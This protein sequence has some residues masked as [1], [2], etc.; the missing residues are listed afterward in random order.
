MRR[1]RKI[2]T[3]RLAILP[4]AYLAEQGDLSSQ[5]RKHHGIDE[6]YRDVITLG[7]CAYQLHTYLAL[8]REHFGFHVET[9]VRVQQRDMLDQEGGAGQLMEHA[10][11]IIDGA[12]R[13]GIVKAS[14]AAGE[15]DIP[16]EMNVALALLL[17][18]P[19]SPDFAENAALKAVRIADMSPNVDWYFSDCLARSQAQIKRIFTSMN[20]W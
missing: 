16:V 11:D 19:E 5:C 3:H 2:D 18:M 4:L 20:R 17:G 10:F 12:L 8:V 1:F 13:I 6:K 9:E 7:I 14:M 15:D